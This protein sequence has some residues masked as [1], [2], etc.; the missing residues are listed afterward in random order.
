[1][2]IE[3]PLSQNKLGDAGWTVITRKIVEF[4]VNEY[5]SW[6]E[7]SMSTTRMVDLGPALEIRNG[8]SHDYRGPDL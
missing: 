6:C 7:L 4:E 5:L 2:N 3:V 8:S 1:M